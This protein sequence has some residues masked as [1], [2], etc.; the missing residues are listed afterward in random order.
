MFLLS[1]LQTTLL[2]GKF[3]RCEAEHLGD[4]LSYRQQGAQ[5]IDK[6]DC[7]NLGGEWINPYLHFDDTLWSLLTLFTIQ[8]TEGWIG[9]MWDSTNAKGV[10]L[11]PQGNVAPYMVIVFIILVIIISM[12]FL[13]LFVGVVIETFNVEK[14]LLS[15]NQLLRPSQKA[16]I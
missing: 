13:N 10:D 11:Q 1:I 12:L 14:E 3:Y 7:I 15:Y 6:W 4:Y 9:V 8:T 5:I 16:W 2:S